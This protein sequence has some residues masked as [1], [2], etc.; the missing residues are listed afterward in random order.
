M[1]TVVD[2]GTYEN[3]CIIELLQLIE[4]FNKQLSESG[5]K[6]ILSLDEINAVTSTTES[7]KLKT[8][9]VPSYYLDVLQKKDLLS[10]PISEISTKYSADSI[11]SKQTALLETLEKVINPDKVLAPMREVVPLDIEIVFEEEPVKAKEV[12]IKQ[13]EL[14]PAGPP[15]AQVTPAGPSVTPA[16]PTP[17]GQQVI[18]TTQ[19]QVTP[20]GPS[21]TT[22]GQQFVPV[23][24]GPPATPMVTQF[25]KDIQQQRFALKPQVSEYDP[26]AIV[27]YNGREVQYKN[28]DPRVKTE[29]QN[30]ILM[31]VNGTIM[32]RD[33]ATRQ[34][35]GQIQQFRKLPPAQQPQYL[36][37]QF[38]SLPTSQQQRLL[39]NQLRRM[40]DSQRQQY[41]QMPSNQQ[42]QYLQQQ[43]F[44]QQ[45]QQYQQPQLLLEAPTDIERQKQ[46]LL[47]EAP[48]VKEQKQL[49]LEEEK[50]KKEEEQKQLLLE[51][52]KRK[53]E[54][55]QKQLALQE[56]KRKKEEEQKQLA[57]QEE[58]RKKE[59]E[60]KQLV[61]REEEQKRN[62]VA[63]I[64]QQVSESQ[65]L[66]PA[67]TS[68]FN[69][70]LL[71][72]QS[73]IQGQLDVTNNYISNT[74]QLYGMVD[75]ERLSDDDR[76]AIMEYI[77]KLHNEVKE[78]DQEGVVISK[79]YELLVSELN[80]R[81]QQN[82]ALSEREKEQIKSDIQ[83]VLKT[84]KADSAKKIDDRDKII[85]AL[86]ER[87]N[88]QQQIMDKERIALTTELQQVQQNYQQD[89]ND[90]NKYITF[91]QQKISESDKYIQKLLEELQNTKL[92]HA[93]NIQQLIQQNYPQDQIE[94]IQKHQLIEYHDIER[95][96]ER[97]YEDKF[98]VEQK[99]YYT[100]YEQRMI[101]IDKQ[102]E[103]LGQR[104]RVLEEN[105]VVSKTDAEK[106]MYK[107]QVQDVV[108]QYDE[109]ESM[110][111]QLMK[112]MQEKS[113]ML[114]QLEQTKNEY[115]N[116]KDKYN[117]IIYQIE[118]MD[119]NPTGNPAIAQDQQ[120]QL[121]QVAQ[122]VDEKK[123]EIA[124]LENQVATIPEAGTTLVTQPAAPEEKKDESIFGRVSNAIF[125][126]S[127]PALQPSTTTPTLPSADQTTV[128]DATQPGA[129]QTVTTTEETQ[130][131][132]TETAVTTTEVTEGTTTTETTAETP[133]EPVTTT[134]TTEETPAATV[135]TEEAPVTTEEK[136]EGE[137][138][139]PGFIQS[140]LS[141]VTRL[142]TRTPETTTPT[143]AETTEVT[144]VSSEETVPSTTEETPVSTEEE[145][146][147]VSSDETA[148]TTTEEEP[149]VTEEEP[150]VTE[151]EPAVTEEEP[152]VTEEETAPVTTELEQ[153]EVVEEIPAVIPTTV[154][155]VVEKKK[156][157]LYRRSR[158]TS[159]KRCKKVCSK[160][161]S[162]KKKCSS[163][164]R[165][166][167]RRSPAQPIIYIQ[168]YPQQ[169]PKM[170]DGKITNMQAIP[171]NINEIIMQNPAVAQPR[172][173]KKCTP[174]RPRVSANKKTSSKNNGRRKVSSKRNQRNPIMETIRDIIPQ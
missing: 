150:A 94:K 46:Q 53:K 41:M 112:E 39:Q 63:L 170:K 78:K 164:R 58:K 48:S 54:E 129:D 149:A 97:A 122:Q 9:Q 83:Y 107:V 36:Q 113:N 5:E 159:S 69:K 115:N 135:S 130:P 32:T 60:Q 12:E 156:R 133:S 47:L 117:N 126:P 174:K 132:L 81:F 101:N 26:N 22:V 49:V 25:T 102:M 80:K 71:D 20:A 163:K 11:Q 166:S 76:M 95:R 99:H 111:E 139:E 62:Q 148:P 90:V 29:L 114:E 61:L 161:T 160:K 118:S 59:E 64:Q 75:K 152:A 88:L 56:E 28:L 138:A 142:F 165:R 109:M 66:V 137:D 123:E 19:A 87:V 116:L 35:Q 134:E 51:E 103:E 108:R 82:I 31:N 93:V 14:T 104:F 167:P 45:L 144:P 4:Q 23:P 67:A 77:V 140:A 136:K 7:I 86:Q 79:K 43:Y 65:E 173:V 37:N 145:Q 153:A 8:L 21:V 27:L 34:L 92:R 42:M 72:T 125:G 6:M 158:S 38:Y 172:P 131:A 15:A 110:K 96:V 154:A 128:I 24:P 10:T 121:Q 162:K 52:E 119:S 17:T 146:T 143:E 68:D 85:G 120:Q 168:Q 33:Q 57:L 147:P 171:M 151:E 91:Y 105:M 16:G 40:P 141:R 50:R 124:Q 70:E 55:E 84:L 106:E 30:G 3:D 169:V 155:P 1:D 74:T 100:T 2:T 127:V 73:N 13:A 98:I 157:V 18:T 44:Q 89:M